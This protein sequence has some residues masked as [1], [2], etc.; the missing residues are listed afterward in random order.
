MISKILNRT[1]RFKIARSKTNKSAQQSEQKAKP[2]EL[3]QEQ[4]FD[5]VQALSFNQYPETLPVMLNT[6]EYINI[7]NIDMSKNQESVSQIINKS[8][9]SPKNKYFFTAMQQTLSHL[10]SQYKVVDVIKLL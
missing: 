4:I 2:L 10:D 8:Y 3:D 6:I 7:N 1:I 9:N 5:I